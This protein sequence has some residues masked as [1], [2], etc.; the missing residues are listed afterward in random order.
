MLVTTS[1][2]SGLLGRLDDRDEA[3]GHGSHDDGRD[4]RSLSAV[5]G[6]AEVGRH[7]TEAEEED[8]G[9]EEQN[10]QEGGW[11]SAVCLRTRP[12]SNAD[13]EVGEV[14]GEVR[15]ADR[16]GAASSGDAVLDALREGPQQQ[17][18]RGGVVAH[19]GLCLAVVDQAAKGHGEGCGQQVRRVAALVDGLL[20]ALAEA[21]HEGSRS[22]G[23]HQMEELG[24]P[25]HDQ[26]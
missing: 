17:G 23:D 13:A 16:Q 15:G 14:A 21:G 25:V 18:L 26:A 10:L 7:A 5:D 20:I 6:V 8:A 11:I 22:K 19:A 3:T 12:Q 24:A 9:A 4:Q 1:R 2:D